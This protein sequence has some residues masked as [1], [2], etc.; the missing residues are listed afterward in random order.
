MEEIP[1]IT[2]KLGLGLLTLSLLAGLSA[3]T[4]KGEECDSAAGEDCTDT[5]TDAD[6]DADADSDTDADAD[7]DAEFVP[8]AMAIDWTTAY[9]DGSYGGWLN[10]DGTDGRPFLAVTLY[11]EAYF[12]ARDDRYSCQYFAY[13]EEVAVD[14]MGVDDLWYGAEVELE[15]AGNTNC[16]NLNPDDWGATDPS[17]FMLDHR[18][19]IGFGP[20][21]PNVSETLPQAVIDAELDWEVDF[22]P[23]VFSWYMGWTRDSAAQFADTDT[24]S[25]W[26]WAR[27]YEVE[28]GT[29]SVDA[30]GN[31]VQLEGG[32]ATEMLDGVMSAN[33]WYYLDPVAFQ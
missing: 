6:A 26:G 32:T 1:M 17:G 21:G 20:L 18:F 22:A 29:L 31:L 23:Y 3:C 2:R 12:D 5:E 15:D 9:A 24:V 7:A 11:E 16:T 19:A 28:D 4:D 27:A 10:T 30:E 13:F 25:D 33:A 14:N 8:Y